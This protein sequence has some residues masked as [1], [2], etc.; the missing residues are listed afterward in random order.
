MCTQVAERW[1]YGVA[2]KLSSGALTVDPPCTVGAS[3]RRPSWAW[4]AGVLRA[5]MS[6]RYQSLAGTHHPYASSDPSTVPSTVQAF[7]D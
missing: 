1:L 6:S 3:H 5:S 4:L 7:N 2:E